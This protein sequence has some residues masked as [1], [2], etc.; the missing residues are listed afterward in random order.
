MEALI[1]ASALGGSPQAGK[2]WCAAIGTNA[3]TTMGLKMNATWPA[4]KENGLL[5]GSENW[6]TL[7]FVNP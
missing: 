2:N 5:K 4:P 3:L 7:R 1:P 6:G